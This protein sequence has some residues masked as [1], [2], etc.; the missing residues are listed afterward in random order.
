M[1]AW[2]QFTVMALFDS[3]PPSWSACLAP[4]DGVHAKLVMMNEPGILREPV[5]LPGISVHIESFP[6]NSL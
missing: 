5:P 2:E 1:E 6:N 4:S 3:Y